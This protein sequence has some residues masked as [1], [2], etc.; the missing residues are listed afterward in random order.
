MNLESFL[1]FNLMRIFNEM[2]LG[3]LGKKNILDQNGL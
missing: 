3:F 1:V 2:F